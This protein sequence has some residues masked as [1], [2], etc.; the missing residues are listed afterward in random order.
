MTPFE[1]K[2][3]ERLRVKSLIKK[4]EKVLLAFSGGADSMALLSLLKKVQPF[5]NLQLAAAHC[6]FGLRGEESDA[7]ETFCQ[8]QCD[9][10]EIPI[11]TIHF[12]TKHFAQQHKMSIEEAARHLRYNFFYK[13]AEIERC[14]KIATA[15]H[16]NDNAE[17]ILFNLFRGSSLL[18]LKGIRVKHEKLVRPLLGFKRAELIEYLESQQLPYRL[19]LTNLSD[20]YDRNFIRLKVIPLIEERFKHKL[21]PNLLRLSENGTE[22]DV[23]LNAHFEKLTSQNGLNPFEQQLHVPSLQML[24]KFEQKEIFKRALACFSIDPNAN[25]LSRLCDLLETQAG[26]KVIL[27]KDLEVI[28]KG[29]WLYFLNG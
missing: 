18:G 4:N 3:L 8:M 2:F 14:S 9:A 24:S 1:K 7:D 19:D 27:S 10:L 16:A 6:N 23:F 17:T 21:L 29:K 22:L 5:L 13:L 28:W 11:F 12:D 20:A 15:H 26:R 25:R